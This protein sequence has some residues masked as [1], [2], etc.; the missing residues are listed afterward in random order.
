R[1]NC[2][3]VGEKGPHHH[4][5]A[6][7][8]RVHSQ[9]LMRHPI[10]RPYD[11]LCFVPCENHVCNI[12]RRLFCATVP[13][14]PVWREGSYSCAQKSITNTSASTGPRPSPNFLCSG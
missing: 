11:A 7:P 13:D 6:V 14:P 12:P 2:F 1:L 4:A 5:G 9:K 10:L 8:E 3:G